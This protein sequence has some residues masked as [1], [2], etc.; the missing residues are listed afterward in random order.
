[1]G[2]R[3][4]KTSCTTAYHKA[5]HALF[6]APPC[7]HGDSPEYLHGVAETTTVVEDEVLGDGKAKIRVGNALFHDRSVRVNIERTDR[8]NQ[9]DHCAQQ[10]PK[11][12]ATETE[13]RHTVCLSP[14]PKQRVDA[15]TIAKST[16]TRQRRGAGDNSCTAAENP[17]AKHHSS[18]TRAFGTASSFAKARLQF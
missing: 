10:Q 8:R 16:G 7:T 18:S 6:T 13:Q 12:G 4:T 17:G 9:D 3:G 11:H 5:P 2:V 1:M 14:K 15:T